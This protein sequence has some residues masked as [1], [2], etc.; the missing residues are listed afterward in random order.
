[1]LNKSRF[2]SFALIKSNS[3]IIEAI[4]MRCFASI[5]LINHSSGESDSNGFT[6]R[7]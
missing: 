2:V 7:L 1:M 4:K 3:R 5:F 6:F